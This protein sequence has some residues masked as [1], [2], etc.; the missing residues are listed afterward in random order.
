[1]ASAQ[2]QRESK[3]MDPYW[4]QKWRNPEQLDMEVELTSG[5]VLQGTRLER[6][7]PDFVE[8]TLESGV[9]AIIWRHAIAMISDIRRRQPMEEG[10]GGVVRTRI[11]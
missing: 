6:V 3:W 5:K 8:V 10:G 1:M 7:E 11:P 4:Y 2:E 9:R